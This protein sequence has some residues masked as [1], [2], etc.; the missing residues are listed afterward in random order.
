MYL[1]LESLIPLTVKT[2][3]L[4]HPTNSPS[5]CDIR[6]P[7]RTDPHRK[8]CWVF[9]R[10]KASG[11]HW[12]LL[13]R[14][15]NSTWFQQIHSSLREKQAPF[16]THCPPRVF[17]ALWTASCLSTREL[18]VCG[19]KG[20]ACWDTY[21]L[22]CLHLSVLNS[23][24]FSPSALFIWNVIRTHPNRVGPH[25]WNT[26]SWEFWPQQGY[27][28]YLNKLLREANNKWKHLRRAPSFP[29]FLGKCSFRL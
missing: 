26:H 3:A 10:I 27:T 22:P 8:N 4:C 19:P 12:P 11:I 14:E 2:L 7:G 29:R 25:S 20:L 21:C 13:S 18:I 16:I 5:L 9:F 1:M 15:D 23:T 17:L 6:N 24:I 28:S